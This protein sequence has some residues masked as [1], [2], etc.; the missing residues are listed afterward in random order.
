MWNLKCYLWAHSSPNED[1]LHSPPI[2]L[3]YSEATQEPVNHLVD[4]PWTESEETSC[5]STILEQFLC[6]PMGLLQTAKYQCV[7]K[8]IHSL[9]L[10]SNSIRIRCSFQ[11]FRLV[12]KSGFSSNRRVGERK[13]IAWTFAGHSAK[14]TNPCWLCD[15]VLPNTASPEEA[16]PYLVFISTQSST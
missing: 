15:N 11:F 3:E 1:A 4:S 2:F 6:A 16:Q 12:Q 7:Q 8:P 5:M 13:K 10:A 14:H 9:E